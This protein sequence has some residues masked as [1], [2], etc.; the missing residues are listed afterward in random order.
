MGFFADPVKSVSDTVSHAGQAIANSPIAMPVL[1]G[2]G[3]MYGVPPWMTASLLGANAGTQRDGELGKGVMTG[4]SSYGIGTGLNSMFNPTGGVVGPGMQAGAGGGGSTGLG[5]SAWSGG[6]TPLDGSL[7]SGTWGSF[8]PTASVLEPSA[9][10]F[11]QAPTLGIASLGGGGGTLGGATTAT[12]SLIGDGSAA[13]GAAAIGSG[14]GSGLGSMLSSNLGNIARAGSSLYS[15]Y[16][17]QQGADATQSAIQDQ[18]QTLTD[19]YKDGSPWANQLKEQLARKDAAAGRNSQYGAR[20]AN[21]Q[22]QLADKAGA[23]AGV[24]GNLATQANAAGNNSNQY[25]NLLLNRIGDV[26]DATGLSSMFK[27]G[28]KDVGDTV[29]DAASGAWDYFFG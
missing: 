28:V 12:G 14:A 1:S 2:L 25:T 19:M 17:G 24:L 20:L 10:A 3:A 16:K 15:A 27:N 6:T 5:S 18:M 22:A 23:N 26:A 29:S 11:G 4:L 21:Y 7:G 9:S 13:A 8:D